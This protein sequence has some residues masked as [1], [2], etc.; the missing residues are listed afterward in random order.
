MPAVL[1][2]RYHRAVPNFRRAIVPGGTF[3][4]T[5]V[6]QG[7]APFLCDEPARRILRTA[8]RE[9]RRRWPF[10]IDAIVLLPDHVHAI[11][12]LPP[13]DSAY[14]KRWA[15]IKKEFTKAWLAQG[16]AQQ[17][18]TDGRRRDSRRGVFQPKFWEHTI[19]NE[20]DFERHVDYIHYNPVK[21]KLAKRPRDWPYSSFH[22]SVRLG[23][24]PIDW[25]CQLN[26]IDARRFSFN[27]ITV[28]ARE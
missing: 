15:W 18:I 14:S 24:Y 20:R 2:V 1:I 27:D 23:L 9:C 11:W 25:G 26:D 8:F 5:V 22:R 10:Q 21:H 3:F 7:R 16:G 28:S 12:N 6:T 17:P 13:N 19:R 4:F